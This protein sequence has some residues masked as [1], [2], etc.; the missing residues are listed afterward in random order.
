MTLEIF[1][2]SW[3]PLKKI[4]GER[5]LP[6]SCIHLLDCLRLMPVFD[7]VFLLL[8][9]EINVII[10]GAHLMELHFCITDKCNVITAVHESLVT[11]NKRNQAIL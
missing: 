2:T 5:T 6:G 7:Y 4:A 11:P 8:I 10:Y 1:I 9:M 3:W